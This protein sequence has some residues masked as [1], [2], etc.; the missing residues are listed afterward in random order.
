M[1]KRRRRPAGAL[2]RPNPVHIHTHTPSQPSP[3]NSGPHRGCGGPRRAG[4][5]RAAG[6]TRLRGAR[7]AG[8][9]PHQGHLRHH[10]VGLG[11]VCWVDLVRSCLVRRTIVARRSPRSS[12]RLNFDTY[13]S[14][15]FEYA[16]LLNATIKLL[17]MAQLS[18]DGS[19]VRRPFFFCVIFFKKCI[20]DPHDTHTHNTQ[21]QPPS[22]PLI[23]ATTAA[24]G[25]RL[26]LHR[27]AGAPHR[28]HQR[29]HQHRQ[30]RLPVRLYFSFLPSLPFPSPLGGAG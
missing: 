4:Q 3:Q 11:A 12:K 23:N 8:P 28:L 9:D 22:P 14:V 21:N 24:V 18:P 5:D 2:G 13:R 27:P 10:Q 17:G 15:D 7:P 30:H 19:K 16:H 6:Q 26:P 20:S 1:V 29:L 25:G